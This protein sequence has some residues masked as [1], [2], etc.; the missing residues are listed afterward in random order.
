MDRDQTIVGQH[1]RLV[2]FDEGAQGIADEDQR[3]G[4]AAGHQRER[5]GCIGG[6]I[7]RALPFD[8][9]EIGAA[10]R[11]M[12]NQLFGSAGCKVGD[13]AVDGD[14]PPGNHDA[15]LAG[16]ERSA[17]PFRKR[18]PCARTRVPTVIF[19]T[20]QSLPIVSSDRR[21][22]AVHVTRE[23]RYVGRFAHVPNRRARRARD[24]AELAIVSEHVR[25]SPLTIS[26]FAC[27][28]PR[29]CSPPVRGKAAASAAPFRSEARSAH[30]PALASRLA[31]IGAVAGEVR[32][33][34]AHALPRNARIDDRNDLVVLRT[35][36]H[37]ARSWRRLRNARAQEPRSG[38][39]SRALFGARPAPARPGSTSLPRS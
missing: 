8:D 5:H 33:H 28:C 25:C 27:E 39:A 2:C 4:R 23:E 11:G 37:R 7:D 21:L 34:L 35:Q 36:S 1:R 31:T 17:P 38:V 9:D 30:I 12:E 14:A 3:I 16:R 26:S 19:P 15:R 13:D 18:A 29:D 32:Q 10:A 20:A 24:A 6:M 22:D